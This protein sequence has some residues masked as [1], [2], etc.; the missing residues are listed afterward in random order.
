M[1]SFLSKSS[2]LTTDKLYEQKYLK[3]KSKYLKYIEDNNKIQKGGGKYKV[4]VRKINPIKGKDI[5]LEIVL[6]DDD[7]PPRLKY[8]PLST[9]DSYKKDCICSKNYYMHYDI[10]G[11]SLD[12]ASFPG[13]IGLSPKEKD[14]FKAY[15]KFSILLY[16]GIIKKVFTRACMTLV[17]EDVLSIVYDVDGGIT[18]K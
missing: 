1:N 2:N 15:I 7:A 8:N 6:W 9:E 10:D 14:E 5:L 13:F 12:E 17:V 16:L 4:L 18:K 11:F 3:Y